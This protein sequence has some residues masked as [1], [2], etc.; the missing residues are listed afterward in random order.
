MAVAFALGV[1]E[2]YHRGVGGGGFLLAHLENGEVIALDMRETAPALA[3]ADMFVRDGVAS[4]ASRLGP[5]AVATPGL[6]V[7]LAEALARWGTKPLDEVLA[8]AIRLA[9]EGFPIGRDTRVCSS[10]A[11]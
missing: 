4:D 9:D 11:T 10:C 1:T 5:L 2:P 8:P 3:T 7:G 6:A